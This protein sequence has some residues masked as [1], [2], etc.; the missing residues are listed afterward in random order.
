M[1]KF[2]AAM[3]SLNGFLSSAWK[4]VKDVVK[5]PSELWENEKL[6][7]TVINPTAGVAVETTKPVLT[8][9]QKAAAELERSKVAKAALAIV[10]N[11]ALAAYG[12]QAEYAK[13]NPDQALVVAALATAAVTGGTSMAALGKIAAGSMASAGVALNQGLTSD[14]AKAA[15]LQMGTQAAG[16][17]LYDMVGNSG[18]DLS[19]IDKF[20]SPEKITSELNKLIANGSIT[21]EQA[22][23][24]QS[25]INQMRS[26]GKTDQEI[27]RELVNS[28]FFKSL[29][30]RTLEQLSYPV[31][32]NDFYSW[33]LNAGYDR[34]TAKRIAELA[35]S[36]YAA[37]FAKRSTDNLVKQ[38]S[39]FDPKLL[40]AAIPVLY[41]VMRK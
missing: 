38:F 31:L 24:M 2:D 13:R 29:S 37:Q 25:V 22:Q 40:L 9:A 26:Q 16:N 7:T 21:K 30:T 17:F 1:N 20:V 33:L 15:A 28:Q 36:E 11:P 27:I 8:S 41:F 14:Q 39:G 6:L 12:G 19:I 5:K 18:L 35:A 3:N 34:D 10:A 23:S 4:G 32:Y